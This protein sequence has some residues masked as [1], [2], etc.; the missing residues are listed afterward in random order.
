MSADPEGDALDREIFHDKHDVATRRRRRVLFLPPWIALAVAAWALAV[1]RPRDVLGARVIAGPKPPKASA[2]HARVQLF[3]A[4][5]GIENAS[6]V[7]GVE[8]R[9]VANGVR[10]RV[11]TTDDQ[12][13]AEVVIDPPL[14]P[15]VDIEAKEDDRY[16]VVGT[17]AISSLPEPDP[18]GGILPV[19]RNGGAI[20]GDLRV[21]VAPELGALAPPIAG[22]I[23]VRVRDKSGLAIARA[24]VSTQVDGGVSGD[25]AT[26]ATDGGGLAR[27]PLL[28]IATPVALTV[29]AESSGKR[30]AW[31][32]IVGTVQ[33]APVPRGDGRLRVGAK[34]I[35]LVAPSSHGSAY[36]DLWQAGVRIAGGRIALE[37]GFGAFPLPP[38]VSGVIDVETNGGPLPA[39]AED[40]AHAATW[41]LVIAVDDVDAW[42]AVA[43]SP[44]FP[45]RLTPAGTL[46]DYG[47][48]V[49]ASIAFAPPAIPPRAIVSDGLE[50]ELRR[51]AKRGRTVRAAASAAVVGGGLVELGLMLWLGVFRSPVTVADAMRELGESVPAEPSSRRW[52]GLLMA[53]VG[54]IALLFAA[55]ATMAWGIP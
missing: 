17:I 53:G 40:L 36:V 7:S 52:L 11:D 47:T 41:P 16:R 44:R 32:G 51:E 23:W 9:V 26:R 34:A 2:L 48:A 1:S 50:P 5:P 24:I 45:E 8:L 22:A 28:P 6:I 31:S 33:G 10:G 18:R 37:G 15:S 13:V 12:G 29:V 19:R 42:G 43:A 21:D 39:S 38:G 55:M 46:A 30:G 4:T 27:V 35:D 14:P 3:R 25:V 49:V 20:T 54:I